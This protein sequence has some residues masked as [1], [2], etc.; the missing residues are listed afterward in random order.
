MHPPEAEGK[1]AQYLRDLYITDPRYDKQRLEEAK[2]G[3]LPAACEWILSQAAWQTWRYDTDA[4]LLWIKGGPGTGKTMLFG[5]IIDQV[6]SGMGED[7]EI[8]YFFCEEGN[9]E[10]S[11]ASAVLRGLCYMLITRS[12]TPDKRLLDIVGEVSD[13]AGAK[14]FDGPGAWYR[15]EKMFRMILRSLGTKRI[16]GT[17]F[18]LVDALNE[19]SENLQNLLRLVV[20]LTG[21]EDAPRGIKWLLTSQRGS[22]ISRKL[23]IGGTGTRS[24]M[25]LDDYSEHRLKALDSFVDHCTKRLTSLQNGLD[26]EEVRNQL[27]GKIGRDNSFLYTALLAASAQRARGGKEVTEIL[28]NA[29]EGIAG[30]YE[31]TIDRINHLEDDIRRECLEVLGVVATAYRSLHHSEL[32]ALT[33]IE[34]D[35]TGRRVIQECDAFFVVNNNGDAQIVNQS[36]RDFLNQSALIPSM[37]ERHRRLFSK[38]LKTMERLLGRDVCQLVHPGYATVDIKPEQLAQLEG[39]GYACEYWIEHLLAFKCGNLEPKDAEAV[40]RVLKNKFL[41]WVE[42]MSV[43]GNGRQAVLPWS[44]LVK[45][46]QV[47]PSRILSRQQEVFSS[48]SRRL[49]P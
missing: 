30:L 32:H 15:L 46:L 42:V 25:D 39:V 47:R 40:G 17:I 28:E 35:E 23:N 38:S 45:F 24:G 11:S 21:S 29:A 26:F 3:I 14:A 4:R 41:N 12:K 44:K 8:A 16:G 19:C 6:V 27:R 9:R 13:G 2:G 34:S 20:D 10:T 31:Q 5:Y 48:S 33:S 43:L 22:S 37:D 18:L 49:S 36:A 7:D 1:E